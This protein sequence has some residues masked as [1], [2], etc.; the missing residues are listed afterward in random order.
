MN[1]EL[2]F[3]YPNSYDYDILLDQFSGTKINSFRTSSIPL[4]QFWRDTNNKLQELLQKLNLY[5]D[6]PTL[7]FEYP[8]KPKKGK[9]KSSMTDLMILGQDFKIAIEA[10]FT[11]Y[12]KY[13]QKMIR[14]W[15]NQNNKENRLKVLDYWTSLIKPFSKGYDDNSLQNISYQFYHRTAS[16][17]NVQGKAYVV[18]QIFY[19]NATHEFLEKYKQKLQ[20]YVRI[21]NPNDN[22]KFYVWEIEVLQKVNDN[23]ENDPFEMMKSKNIY[24]FL[25]TNLSEL[26]TLPNIELS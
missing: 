24:E 3:G 10:K 17:C 9:G 11:E 6:N 25:R 19:D 22:L 4:V 15:I 13:E 23:I 12:A 1:L 16:A 5:A 14:N 8:T 21:I 20:D 26:K 7:C 2:K 18:Y